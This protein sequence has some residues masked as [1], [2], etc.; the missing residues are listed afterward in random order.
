MKRMKN[1]KLRL[2][3]TTLLCLSTFL[4]L[5]K[6]LKEQN[7]EPLRGPSALDVDT[8]KMHTLPRGNFNDLNCIYSIP[9]RLNDQ[10]GDMPIV[11]P[12]SLS[13]PIKVLSCLYHR[14]VT[15]I[16]T[17]CF[18]P[19]SF[20]IP[21]NKGGYI[22]V[23]NDLLPI[24]DCKVVISGTEVDKNFTR[25]L[26]QQYQCE[27]T[28]NVGKLKEYSRTIR[29]AI[30][31]ST[32]PLGN[33]MSL[34][35]SE[36]EVHKKINLIVLPVKTDNDV[37]SLIYVVHDSYLMSNIMQ[38]SLKIYYDPRKSSIYG[39]KKRLRLL[40]ELYDLGF[41]IFF[42]TRELECIFDRISKSKFVSCYSVSFIRTQNTASQVLIPSDVQ[43]RTMS[44]SQIVRMYDR[45]TSS[46]QTMCQQNTRMGLIKDGGW[47][48]C[49]DPEYRPK[50]PCLVYSFGIRNDFSFD[51]ELST[52]YGCHVFS[53][54][55]SM[56]KV[57]HKH[58]ENVWFKNIGISGENCQKGNWTLRTVDYIRE[59]LNHKDR[60][61]DILKMDVE[62][63][64]WSSLT[65]MLESDTLRY[66]KQLLVEFHSYGRKFLSYLNL[67][68]KLFDFGFRI[69]WTHKNS[70]CKFQVDWGYY[71]KCTEVYFVNVN[72][73]RKK[74]QFQKV[75]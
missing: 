66:V 35:A 11:I 65:Q 58:S 68:R 74:V 20:G 67:L 56:G 41:R 47:N 72:Y 15:T 59:M 1:S 5:L 22:C 6:N 2:I 34:M 8:T 43:L 12:N 24:G 18:E 7:L 52:V 19:K 70:Y 38:I 29:D 60:E 30:Q 10:P 57:D 48:I 23:D 45:Y 27:I 75:K 21:D 44:N 28:E 62:H 36:Q 4:Y 3:I 46:L 31:L 14:Y 16:Q 39:Y 42:F 71:T 55:P 54:D 61:I 69:F 25:Q 63:S 50:E 73:V 17:Q 13:F 53:F 33:N 40:K 32:T 64:E 37:E 51:D 26:R 9:K 49:H